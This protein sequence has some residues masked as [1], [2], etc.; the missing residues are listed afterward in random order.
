MLLLAALAALAPIFA[1]ASEDLFG[2]APCELCLWQ[3]WPYWAAAALALAAAA[4]PR[5]RRVLGMLAILAVLASGAVAAF[6]V[7]VEQGWWP[8]PLAGCQ[9]PRAAPGGSVEDMLR[10]MSTRPSKPC[11]APAYLIEG[12]P[13]SMAA[14]N[15]LYALGLSALGLILLRKGAKA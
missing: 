2:L 3:R 11:D 10:A 5:G 1:R 12:L 9:A 7:G 8:S 13:V 6:H 4:W 15:L 14:M